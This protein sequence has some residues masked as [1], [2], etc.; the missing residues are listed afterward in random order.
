MRWRLDPARLDVVLAGVLLV[1]RGGAGR[2]QRRARL[3][4]AL[5][6]GHSGRRHGV[7][8]DP[9]PVPGGR[10]DRR[11]GAAGGRGAA[12]PPARGRVTVAWF[13]ALYALAV[14][15][16][17]PWFVAGL[18]FFVGVEPAASDRRSGQPEGDR[19]L[20]GRRR[21]GHGVPADHRRPPRPAAGHRR[22]GTRPGP[23]GGGRRGA[24][25]DRPRAARRDRAPRLDDGRAGG[26]RAA[27]ARPGPGVDAGGAVDDRAGRPQRAHRDAPA[28]R[29]AARRRGRRAGAA[30]EPRRG[31]RPGRRAAGR[32][33]PGGAADRRRAP[34]A[35]GR[36]SSCPR[37]A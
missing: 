10:R 3:G 9:A 31:A 16:T 11:P 14:W 22:A 24:R 1:D 6:S 2:V 4:A 26:R 19:R 28:G 23:A 34:R 15:T 27:G 21:P 29:D 37:T 17:W 32:R 25:P 18:A 33:L 7:G 12:R 5:R 13:C 8:G 36:A 35:P 30:A 20:H